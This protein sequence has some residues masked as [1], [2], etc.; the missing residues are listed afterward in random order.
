MEYRLLGDLGLLIVAEPGRTSVRVTDTHPPI[1][2]SALASFAPLPSNVPA[3]EAGVHFASSLTNFVAI[4]GPCG[5]GKTHLLQAI[6]EQ[7]QR[8][9]RG[10]VQVMD[11]HRALSAPG[12]LESARALLLDDV[13]EV[14]GK[15]KL[16]Q[17]L[18]VLLERR[19]KGSRPTILAFT[20]D[21][22]T[23]QVKLMLPNS[24]AWTYGVIS[25][26]EAIERMVILRQMAAKE[27]LAMSEELIK[28]VA[29]HMRVNG[30]TLSGA[31]KRLRLGGEDWTDHRGALEALG[32]LN[33]FFS[34]NPDWDLL[35]RI[36][37]A[38]IELGFPKE[39]ALYAM[40]CIANVPETN[41]ARWADV[42]PAEA[43]AVTKQFRCQISGNPMANERISILVERVVLSL[44]SE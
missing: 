41:V 14:F 38:S 29:G 20:G 8:Q 2:T 31:L 43:F 4:V 9:G 10:C 18:R 16:R 26:P 23:R 33:P 12:R 24:R 37:R 1:S 44:A 6:A 40:M 15:P 28:I 11:I 5:W 30:R 25:E 7:Y 42:E 34:D 39:Y 32:V 27:G 36:H 19:M 13:Q 22:P 35:H 3:F 21:K 17:L